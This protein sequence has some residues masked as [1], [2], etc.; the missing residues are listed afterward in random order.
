[1]TREEFRKELDKNLIE[2]RTT[3]DTCSIFGKSG[4]GVGLFPP[5]PP[6]FKCRPALI[7]DVKLSKPTPT[8]R[9]IEP[10]DTRGWTQAET[11]VVGSLNFRCFEIEFLRRI[12]CFPLAGGWGG[13]GVGS[14]PH[15]C[16]FCQIEH[17]TRVVIT[18]KSTARPD[19]S[20]NL[21]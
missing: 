17:G 16:F 3:D 12:R 9:Q 11:G 8:I 2:S 1:M 10:R 13:S 7:G 14:Y 19:P 6:N 5:Q 18:C 20:H 15:C 21:N 4:G